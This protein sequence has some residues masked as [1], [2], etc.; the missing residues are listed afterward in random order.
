[1]PAIKKLQNEDI[2]DKKRLLDIAND[3][4]FRVAIFGSAR[5]KPEDTI[6]QEVAELARKLAI[7]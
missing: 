6:Y 5:I 7:N 3:G 4:H 1:M 2:A